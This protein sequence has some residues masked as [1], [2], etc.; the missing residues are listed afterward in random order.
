MRRGTRR[1]PRLHRI[2]RTFLT[3]FVVSSGIAIFVA[4]KYH[5]GVPGTILSI[6]MGGGAPAGAY[7]GWE[8]FVLTFRQDVESRTESKVVA[9]DADEL[10]Q[11]VKT[12]WSDEAIVRQFNDY[13]QLMVTWTTADPALSVGWDDLVRL[14][15]DGPGGPSPPAD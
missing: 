15:S 2:R 8:G 9:K 4:Y 5:L 6:A 7:L 1:T 13:S 10:A 14:A 11:S 3:I 12:Q